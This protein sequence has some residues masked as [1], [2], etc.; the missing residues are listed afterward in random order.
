MVKFFYLYC[1]KEYEV[2]NRVRTANNLFN[3]ISTT[4]PTRP[5]RIFWH[6]DLFGI[7]ENWK[8]ANQ[9]AEIFTKRERSHVS[10]V[11]LISKIWE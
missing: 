11:N 5:P 9:N 10:A 7:S 3:A 4:H 1:L 8:N 2:K 6:P